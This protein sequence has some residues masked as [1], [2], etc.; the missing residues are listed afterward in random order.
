MYFMSALFK[1]FAGFIYIKRIFRLQASS[2]FLHLF[3]LVKIEDK[4]WRALG[5]GISCHL[6]NLIEK[7]KH[8][9]I[10]AN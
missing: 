3:T 6:Q 4:K 8:L 5:R 1:Q 9:A 10:Y 7:L 2:I